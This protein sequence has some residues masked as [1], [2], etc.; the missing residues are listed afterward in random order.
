MTA[1]LFEQLVRLRRGA[2]RRAR[3]LL[4]GLRCKRFGH[5]V[6]IADHVLIFCPE[7]IEIGEGVTINDRV[8]L[9]SC[10]GAGLTIGDRAVLSYG[11]YVLTG[12]RS[13]VE[14]KVEPSHNKA[15]VSIGPGAWIGAGAIV[16][17]GVSIG[18]SAVVGAGSVV[19]K[20][21]PEGCKVVGSP[22]R[23]I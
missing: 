3:R 20:D 16:L 2:S 5:G 6:E 19:T 10:E 12:G 15:P 9:Q 7:F 22:A 18:A 4:Y 8:I 14:E 1:D 23:P 17:P 13:L 11:A 21:V